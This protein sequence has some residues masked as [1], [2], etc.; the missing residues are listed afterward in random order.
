MAKKGELRDNAPATN[1][2][3]TGMLAISLVALIAGSVLLFLDYSQYEGKPNKPNLAPV[4]KAAEDKGNVPQ[5]NLA[6]M[7]PME[8]APPMPMPNQQAEEKANP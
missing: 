6:P 3:Y 2:A 4:Q 1:D 8:K 7:N 5:P